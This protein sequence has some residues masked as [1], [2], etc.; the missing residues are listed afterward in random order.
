MLTYLLIAFIIFLALAPLSHFVPSKAQRRTARMR[1]RA[2]MDGLFV[3]FRK[4]PGSDDRLR[5]SPS[6]TIYYGLRHRSREEP[7]QRR[8]FLRQD[9]Q[10]RELEKLHPPT[11]QAWLADLPAQV[12]AA[13]SSRD[14][15]GVYWQEAGEETEVSRIAGVLKRRCGL[16]VEE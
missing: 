10:W 15:V 11:D 7:A 4:L 13:E 8:Q 12:Q 5:P 9:E 1:E 16:A 6:G 14:G 2:A 3:E